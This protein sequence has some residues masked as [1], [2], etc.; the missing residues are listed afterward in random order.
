MD[1]PVGKIT[2]YYEKIGVAVVALEDTLRVGDTIKI[3]S[4]NTDFT[5]TVSSMQQEHKN[6]E[7]AKKGDIVGLKVDQFVKENDLIYK[8]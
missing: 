8:A 6:I 4:E 1:K 2:H 5:Q 3:K 7:D